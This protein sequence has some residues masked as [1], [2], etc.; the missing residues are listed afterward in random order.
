MRRALFALIFLLFAVPVY[1][2]TGDYL[3]KFYN[4][5]NTTAPISTFTVPASAFQC[6]QPRVALPPSP[7]RNPL[8]VKFNDPALPTRDCVWNSSTAPATGQGPIF[9]LPIT[10]T[11]YVATATLIVNGSQ[12]DESDLSNAFFRAPGKPGGVRVG[13]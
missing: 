7:I 4:V 5:G 3:L 2:Q 1:A 6:D 13:G 11:G 10:G 9:A 12:S 8:V